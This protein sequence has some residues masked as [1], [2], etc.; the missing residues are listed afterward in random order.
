[1]EG[2]TY[3]APLVVKVFDEDEGGLISSDSLEFLGMAALPMTD[4]APRENYGLFKNPEWYNLR[5]SDTEGFGKILMSYTL[6]PVTIPVPN[7]LGPLIE[8]SMVREYL[9]K[10]KILG[11]RDL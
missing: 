2:E 7:T 1:M 3:L 10:I 4:L 11:L 6:H 8:P 5:Y 9:V